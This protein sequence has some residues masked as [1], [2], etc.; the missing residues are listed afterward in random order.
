MKRECQAY[1]RLAKLPRRNLNERTGAH[2]AKSLRRRRPMG[3]RRR[4]RVKAW[5]DTTRGCLPVRARAF[6]CTSVHVTAGALSS[7]P[8]VLSKR[9][10]LIFAGPLCLRRPWGQADAILA[11]TGPRRAV[12]PGRPPY[13]GAARANTLLDAGHPSVHVSKCVGNLPLDFS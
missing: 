4:W 1:V 7:N 8:Q 11:N 9:I 6:A 13:W 3:R 2:K 12:G 10:G 5:G